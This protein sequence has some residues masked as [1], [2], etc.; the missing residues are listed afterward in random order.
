MMLKVA[1]F[2]FQLFG[3]NTYVVWDPEQRECAVIDPG[4]IDEG[5]RDAL[6]RFIER[7][8][9][10]VT[11]LINTHLH[12][13]HAIGNGAVSEDYGAK[14]EAHPD[15]AFLGKMLP[16]QSAAFSLGVRADEA[17]VS[18][19]LK[20]GDV[21][22]I[23]SGELKVIHVPGHS[24]GHIALYCADARPPFLIAGDVLFQRSIGRTDLPGGDFQTLISSIKDKLF[25]L[26]DNTVVYP[27]HGP[28]T[29]IGDEKRENP[30]VR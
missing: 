2:Q 5:E 21:I 4:I 11:H 6:R 7:E 18:I 26:P 24:P 28:A 3:I 1:I 13:D 25:K 8:G 23:G 19:P 15:D 12:I 20:E 29:T 9:L 22:K 27:G 14:L 17:E 30:Y 10:T 16:A